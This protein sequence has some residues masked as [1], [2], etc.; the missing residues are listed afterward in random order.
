MKMK[1]YKIMQL[2]LSLGI[3]SAFMLTSCSDE[4][5]N[6][7][8]TNPNNP[9]EVPSDLLI[10]QTTA[11]T[12][13]AICGTDLAWYSSVFVE[14]TTG[15]HGQLETADKRTGIN[16]SIGNNSWNDLYNN[17]KD[18]DIIIEMCS[19]GGAEEGN[20]YTAGIAK[21][22][23][24]H[25]YSI[26]TDIWGEIPFVEALAG[27]DIRQPAFDTEE[28]VYKGIIDLLDEAITDLSGESIGHPGPA[29]FFYNG[30]AASWIKAAYAL[31]ARFYNRL[32]NVRND[33]NDSILLATSNAFADASENMV[34]TDFSTNATAQHPWF[35]EAADRGHHAISE[36]L[37]GILQDLNDPRR[38]FW[39][40][41]MPSGEIVPAPNGT[42]TT[43]QGGEIYS[44]VKST[45][46]TAT[47]PMPIIT[48]DELKFIEAET[49]LREG[50]TPEAYT[51]YLEGIEEAMI[52]TGITDTTAIQNYLSQAQVDVGESNLDLETIITQ[53]YV[54][55]WMFQPIEAYNDYRRT[56]IPTLN[57]PVSDPPSR[58][59]YPTDEVAANEENV[60]DKNSSDLV[61]WA[62]E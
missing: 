5:L 32:S 21:I 54:A 53:K 38:T 20:N 22:L 9:V 61:W 12:A 18:L 13:F 55:F 40:D 58:F 52:R 48:Y 17:M 60:P 2:L 46:L 15:V 26:T 44:R 47:S 29:D 14:H 50:N 27:S 10:A 3:V 59:P 4:K 57:N 49:H 56:G 41:T 7:I 37:D 31:K 6:E 1:R 62:I 24:A 28:N 43:D 35:Q 30:D 23:L 45:Y 51:A 16:S 8:G 19:E 42:A 33:I 39:I 25:N 11:N 34:F 36:T